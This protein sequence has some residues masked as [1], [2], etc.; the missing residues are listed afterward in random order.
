[1]FEFS[2]N[3]NN[4]IVKRQF[5]EMAPTILKSQAGYPFTQ[6]CS[7]P[8]QACVL[9]PLPPIAPKRRSM[10]RSFWTTLLLGLWYLRGQKQARMGAKR[11]L[12]QVPSLRS[13][14]ASQ[15]QWEGNNVS[16][17]YWTSTQG[18]RSYATQP[19]I[20]LAYKP[21]W[22]IVRW[23]SGLGSKRVFPGQFQIMGVKYNADKRIPA[24]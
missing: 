20:V 6:T 14:Q 11:L 17:M 15:W 16:L 10:K 23:T 22:I 9:T 1:M 18:W 7:S 13:G 8:R 24:T 5:S 2:C 21:G 19:I 4:N 12:R 3:N